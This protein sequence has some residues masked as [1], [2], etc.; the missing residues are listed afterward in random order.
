MVTFEYKGPDG[1]NERTVPKVCQDCQ[2]Y[3][4]HLTSRE[5]EM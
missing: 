2:R 3:R 5:L 1:Y 4:R